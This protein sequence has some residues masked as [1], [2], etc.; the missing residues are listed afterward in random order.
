MKITK[1]ILIILLLT[2]HVGFAQK[3]TVN[4][5]LR[6][7]QFDN[8]R[9]LPAEKNFNI[10]IKVGASV[11]L[12]ELEIAK[13]L[14]REPFYTSS[15]QKLASELGGYALLPVNY[16]LSS[17][18]DFSFRIK[19]YRKLKQEDKLKIADQ[20]SAS[21]KNY[22]KSAIVKGRNGYEFRES[23]D[24]LFKALNEIV[25][26]GLK[27]VKP[28]Y[29]IAKD[30]YSSI[31]EVMIKNLDGVKYKSLLKDTAD[32]NYTAALTDIE[33][34]IDNEIV[35]MVNSYTFILTD[36]IEIDSYPSEKT[37]NFL[38]VN[39]GY[40]AVYNSGTYKSLNYSS[41]PVVGVSFPLA[42]YATNNSFISRTSFSTG[43][44]LQDFDGGQD[45]TITGP[46]INKPIYAALGY[47]F[48][49]FVKV[50]AGTSIVQEKYNLTNTRSNIKFK[51]FISLGIEL[52]LW[53]GLK[54]R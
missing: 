36:V 20:I 49:N 12:V 46:L 29:G 7:K 11:E 16:K 28:S 42:N 34:Q 15:W 31:L 44:F 47:R 24:K 18:T 30:S 45:T 13:K 25:S 23:Y 40:G 14:D 17:A 22:L 33:N 4:L 5:D 6:T 27:A 53:L 8:G 10:A 39:A 19:S 3:P 26:A 50:S 9:L 51:P 2:A 32:A 52:D 48:L 41:G 43:L 38:S 1:Y 37:M 35:Q 21:S 54:K